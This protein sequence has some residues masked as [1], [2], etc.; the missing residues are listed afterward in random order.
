MKT[1]SYVVQMGDVPSDTG[2]KLSTTATSLLTFCFHFSKEGRALT[3]GFSQV[4]TCKDFT[5]FASVF[6]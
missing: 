4:Y 5:L 2:M 1:S 3:S 6:N